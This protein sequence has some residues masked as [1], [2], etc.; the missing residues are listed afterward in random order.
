M[1]AYLNGEFRPNIS[2]WKIWPCCIAVKTGL[3]SLIFEDQPFPSQYSYS[4][5]NKASRGGT[6]AKTTLFE[7]SGAWPYRKMYLL[8]IPST[9]QKAPNRGSS[10]FHLSVISS[11]SSFATTYKE[12]LRPLRTGVTLCL[13]KSLL[14]IPS[15]GCNSS[16]Q[17][18]SIINRSS[19]Q[20]SSLIVAD[21][22]TISLLVFM[23]LYDAA[24]APEFEKVCF[25]ISFSREEREERWDFL[26]AISM[27]VGIVDREV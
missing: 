13:K 27:T 16:I 26:L 22:E 8:S 21:P 2:V 4:F 12:K 3:D 15:D 6:R 9:E 19:L 17:I 7:L 20:L 10:A 1:K 11:I 24:K 14:W 25:R 5:L 23:G 18:D